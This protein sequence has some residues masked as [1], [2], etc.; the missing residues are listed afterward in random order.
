[1]RGRGR[2]P[3]AFPGDGE[4]REARVI[5]AKDVVHLGLPAADLVLEVVVEFLGPLD[6]SSGLLPRVAEVEVGKG[7]VVGEAVEAL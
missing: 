7:G 5:V 3:F 4:A 2:S 6:G 1:M